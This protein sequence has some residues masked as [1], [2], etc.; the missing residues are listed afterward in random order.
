MLKPDSTAAI[1]EALGPF[2][3][4]ARKAE[5]KAKKKANKQ[6]EERR[7]MMGARQRRK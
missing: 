5:K 7:R 6:A 4:A 3:K 2:D 1:G